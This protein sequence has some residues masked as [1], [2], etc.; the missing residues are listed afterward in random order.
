MVLAPGDV[1]VHH[2]NIVH[3][4]NA[5]TSPQAALRPDD[6]LHPDSD[7][8]HGSEKPYPSAFHLQGE[9]GVN[10]YQPRPRYDESRHFPFVGST[11]GSEPSG[12]PRP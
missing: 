9:P 5:N 10:S 6:P 11:T 4:S 2:P 12:P 3:G 7:E 1:E 8:D